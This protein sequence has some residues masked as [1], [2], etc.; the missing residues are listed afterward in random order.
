MPLKIQNGTLSRLSSRPK[1]AKLLKDEPSIPLQDVLE[2]E[3]SIL[4]ARWKLI[5]AY[6]LAY[7]FWRFYES[8][9]LRF[10]WTVH[11]VHFMP[12]KLF[13]DSKYCWRSI[14]AS[15]PYLSMQPLSAIDE[16]TAETYDM[17][18]IMHQFPRIL[19]LGMLLV[20]IF[21][22]EYRNEFSEIGKGPACVVNTNCVWAMDIIDSEGWPSLDLADP[23]VKE[24]YKSIVRNCFPFGENEGIF[25]DP[26]LSLHERRQRL[27]D[28]VVLPLRN[29]LMDMKLFSGGK[30]KEI[31]YESSGPRDDSRNDSVLRGGFTNNPSSLDTISQSVRFV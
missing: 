25:E 2:S 16:S 20:Q 15:A 3:G 26:P 28:H 29:I 6:I 19:A 8:D 30:I 9:W 31:G 27:F 10:K 21:Q 1:R 18:D 7:S 12:G 13:A 22:G 5:L 24:R 14:S 4:S 17:T 23:G 11:S